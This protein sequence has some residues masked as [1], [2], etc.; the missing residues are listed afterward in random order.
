M[1]KYL[2]MLCLV[3]SAGAFAN[4]DLISELQAL[5][6]E[7]STLT[8]QEQ[9]RFNEEKAQAQSAYAALQQNEQTYAALTQRIEML[10]AQAD[11]R[12]YKSEY[13]DLAKK[14]E[15]TLKKLEKEMEEQ[16]KIISDFQKI[17][18]LRAGN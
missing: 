10:K 9:Q 12:F 15:A 2:V 16:R 13:Q 5:E 7:F 6:S 4:S 11:T 8:N 17:E 18:Q 14:Y 3:L 1:K